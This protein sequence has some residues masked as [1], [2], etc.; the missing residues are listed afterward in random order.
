MIPA[1]FCDHYVVLT[2]SRN[3]EKLGAVAAAVHDRGLARLVDPGILDT[4]LLYA[5]HDE[6]YVSAFLDGRPPLA[7]SQ[8]LAWSEALR[9]AV[10]AMQAGQLRS[11][12]LALEEG[13]AA[14]IANGFHHARVARGGGFCTFNGLAL[15]AL[16]FP[17]RR[18]FVLDCDE[19]GGNGT[20]EFARR[21]PNLF[22]YSIFG[23]RFGCRGGVRSIADAI[24]GGAGGFGQYRA[25]LYRAFQQART[26]RPD[27]ILYQ[28]GVDCHVDDPIG[29]GSLTEEDL[30]RRDRMV[31]DF[32]RAEGIPVAFSLAGGYRSLESTT[33]LHLN[34]FR[35]ALSVYRSRRRSGALT[36]INKGHADAG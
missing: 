3:M 26:W 7:S 9:G 2:R 11:A 20:E 28:A 13:V 33:A 12:R 8:N 22:N 29:R 36:L 35:A 1:C 15:V 31:F 24:E 18:V 32:C 6:D 27:L 21:L 5:L 19:H 23:K 4:G 34:T 17:E 10:L 30:A 16:T 14:N 25:A